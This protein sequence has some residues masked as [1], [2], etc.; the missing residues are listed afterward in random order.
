MAHWH[1]GTNENANGLL[2]QYFPKGTDLAKRSR[3]D[4]AAAVLALNM[5][6][7]KT[8]DWN[9]PAETLDEVLRST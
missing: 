2:R 4:L 9:T 7:R 1:R 5:R 6:P 3:E 8:L